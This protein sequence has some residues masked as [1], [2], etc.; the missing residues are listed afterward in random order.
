VEESALDSDGGHQPSSSH[1]RRGVTLSREGRLLFA[2]RALRTFCLGWLSLVLALYLAARG[3]SP[4]AIGAVFTATL[5]E[6]A[7]LTIV[8]SA[9]AVRLG[10]RRILIGA[11][12]AM[13]AGGLLLA[14]AEG[15]A[16][17]I[18]AV[19]LATVSLGGQEAG[20]FSPLEQS[21]LPGT[22]ATSERTRAFAWYN[23]CG[24]VPAGLGALAAG[25]WLAT[26]TRLGLSPETTDLGVMGVYVAG[27][28]ALAV[29]YTRLPPSLDVAAAAPS[30]AL[31]ARPWLGLHRSRGAV[32]Q[33][34][35]LQALDSFGGGFV[36][37]SLLV[38]WFHLRFGASPETLGPVF[39]GTNLLSAVSF[40]L[41][42]RVA[43]RIGLLNTMV[44]TH[45]PSNVLL[46]LV[47][48]APSLP[49]A[50]ALL[51]ARH[52]L[53]QM[54]VPTRQAYA[55][56]LVTPDERAAAAGFTTSA[57]ALAQALSPALTGFAL[58]RAA[59]GLPFYL[60]GGLKIVYDLALYFRFRRLALPAD[61][62]AAP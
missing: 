61:E 39:F 21:L 25:G 54:D 42:A 17:V 3:L 55:M 34:S 10:R 22:V 7:L 56:A 50:A 26:A 45:L 14:M 8:L 60:A 51:L 52:L 24:F 46:V 11:A 4:A 57:R 35:G 13:A 15:H 29:L 2:G 49:A 20:P 40:P 1:E 53:A 9:F 23:V 59:T 5:V 48:L 41:A 58:A 16:F 44:F 31:A 36:V 38:Y 12:L 37:Q 6:D 32:L 27:A 33:L 43:E 18:V 30:A 19:I 28:L 47:P 62:A